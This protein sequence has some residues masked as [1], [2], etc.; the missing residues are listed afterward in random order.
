VTLRVVIVDDEPLARRRLAAMV[1]RSAIAEV[2]GQAE[3]ADHALALIARLDPDVALVDVRMPPGPSGLEL[4]RR[5]GARPIVVFTTAH[6]EHAV[7]AFDAAAADYLLKP[8]AEDK[9][10]RALDR[11][12]VRLG[13]TA[14]PHGHPYGGSAVAGRIAV[15]GAAE[16]EPR[17]TA[18][19][20]AVVR[21]FPARAIARFR[22]ADKYTVFVA[23]GV[24]HLTE[25]SLGALEL[26]L[27]AW[28][29]VRVHRAE[30]VQVAHVRALHATDAG[31][32]LEL[33]GG[34]RVPVS[35]RL[36]PAVRRVLA[37]G[38]APKP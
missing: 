25:E 11:A 2:V 30:L 20:G 37:T 19:A 28:G 32:E 17:I 27:A 26:R 23:D 8:V 1:G 5:L 16:H 22:A 6:G 36:L 12:A 21:V 29:F 18:R 35:R 13:R 33:D 10:A 14:A 38:S 9:L 31:A 15:A 34:D 7:D 3:N 24:E 4:A